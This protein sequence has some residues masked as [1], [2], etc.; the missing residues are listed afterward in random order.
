MTYPGVTCSAVL[1]LLPLLACSALLLSQVQPCRQ[2]CRRFPTECGACA[3]A[4]PKLSSGGGPAWPG[5][6]MHGAKLT[7]GQAQCV[8]SRQRLCAG[9]RCVYVCVAGVAT[10]CV[11]TV[12]LARPR[13]QAVRPGPCSCILSII[14][15]SV[16]LGISN[17]TSK[18]STIREPTIP[19]IDIVCADCG[20]GGVPP[21]CV[22]LHQLVCGAQ[23]AAV[24]V[25]CPA[26]NDCRVLPG[27]AACL[28]Q[29]A[30]L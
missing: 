3:C 10:T 13:A 20:C 16:L 6:H 29:P 19:V 17:T 1:P 9:R 18:Q 28:P 27:W 8:A 5:G 14:Q 4:R 2:C 24:C 23:R 7:D 15:A 11:A 30:R 26:A 12:Q 25:R 22:V 21:V